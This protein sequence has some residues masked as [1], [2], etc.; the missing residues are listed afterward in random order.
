MR[1]G[2]FALLLIKLEWFLRSALIHR[3]NLAEILREAEMAPIL[4]LM[5][6]CRSLGAIVRRLEIVV[7]NRSELRLSNLDLVTIFPLLEAIEQ[8]Y[9]SNKI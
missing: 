6:T 5:D 9:I 8:L 4:A 1:I 7:T 2:N 3:S